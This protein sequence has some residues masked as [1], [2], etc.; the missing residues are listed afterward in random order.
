MWSKI[1][2]DMGMLMSLNN[3]EYASEVNYILFV[4]MIPKSLYI[5]H[6]IYFYLYKL[7]Y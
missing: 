1:L 2:Q 5:I 6:L 7:S 3:V 4:L